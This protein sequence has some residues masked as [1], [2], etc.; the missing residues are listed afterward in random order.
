MNNIKEE[1]L[2]KYSRQI[3]IDEVGM[4]GQKK[5]C[6]SSISIVGCGGL[7]TSA[8]QYLSMSGVGSFTLIDDDEISLSNLNR[9]T[10]FDE[11]DIGRKKS[12]VLANKICNINNSAKIK[13]IEEK[14]SKKNI[15][16]CL[17]DSNIILDCTDNFESRIIINKFC[18]QNK[19]ILISAALQN[20]E[21]Q[22]FIFASWKNKKN[23]CYKCIFPNLIDSEENIGCDEMGIISTVAGIG[24]LL[25][26]N[27]ALNFILGL[28]KKFD[29]FILFDSV[30]LNIKKILVKKNASCKTCT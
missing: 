11:K 7:G 8:A 5:I 3:I 6:E 24:G 10:L 2:E 26:A 1:F 12:Y 22:A 16:S 30:S 27:L 21:I 18:H 13:H 14:V 17:K 23:P 25:Q 20:F 4:D 29:E 19:K 15:S 9:Q 28:R